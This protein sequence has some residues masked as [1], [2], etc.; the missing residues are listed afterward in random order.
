VYTPWEK[1]E[2]SG[3]KG[4]LLV[5]YLKISW[6]KTGQKLGNEYGSNIGNG[7][8]DFVMEDSYT[9]GVVSNK[10]EGKVYKRNEQE[11]IRYAK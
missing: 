8:I 4:R 11:G 1:G 7:K 3:V 2:S 5:E 9:L 10:R 6:G